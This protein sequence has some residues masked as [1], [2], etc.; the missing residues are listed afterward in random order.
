MKTKQ[1]SR[2]MAVALSILM[3]F[4]LVNW[5]GMLGVYAAEENPSLLAAA[6]KEWRYLSD[7]DWESATHGD[8]YEHKVVQK[9]KSFT[10]GNDN[11]LGKISLQM[12]DGEIR[13][14][15]KGLG[16]I[17]K[18]G[19]VPSIITYNLTGVKASH[20]FSY[21]GIDRSA[22]SGATNPQYG[23]VEKIEV[24]VDDV[25]KFTTTEPVTYHTKAITI[26]FEI[27]E[28]ASKLELKSY[29]GE[30]T[31][32]DEVVFADAR[33]AV[34]RTA[35][36]ITPPAEEEEGWTYLS[37][38]DW[39]EATHGDT[40]K[41]KTVQK[42]KPFSPGNNGR[43]NKIA[44]RMSAGNYKEFE[45]GLGT[46]AGPGN[47]PAV[48]TY[49]LR[50]AEVSEFSTYLGIDR[51]ATYG[52]QSARD[53]KV[54]VVVD[55]QVLYTTARDYPN[56]LDY[57]TDAVKV[58]VNIP[59]TAQKFELK[60]YAGEK[61][62]SDELCF[63]DAKFK[64][65]GT[66]RTPEDEGFGEFEDTSDTSDTWE[67]QPKRMEISNSHPLLMVPLYAHGPKYAKQ[68]RE[69]SFWGDD[70][71]EGKW[72]SIPKELKPYT[73][74]QLHPDDLGYDHIRQRYKDKV[75]AEFYEHHLKLAQEYIDPET[76]EN[77]PI[78]I[79]LT[80][81]TAG[82]L[83]QYTPSYWL[84]TEW[85]DEMYKKYSCLK[86]VFSTE[87]Y[88]IWQGDTVS[89]ATEYLKVSAKNGGYFIWSE[90]NAGRSIE[91][92]M[93]VNDSPELRK[94]LEKYSDYFV[95][96]YKNTPQ[97]SGNDAP[98]V[99]YMKGLWLAGYIDQWGGLMDTWKWYETGK[100]KL[101]AEGNI[102]K[103]QP[104]RQWEIQPEAMLGMESL[105]IYLNG[106][107]VYNYEHPFYTYGVK[108]K[109][110]PLFN[111]VITDF[112][113]Y[114]IEHPAPSKE[115]VL[116]NTKTMLRIN[117]G[118][119][120]NGSFFA[121]LNIE[122]PATSLYTTGRYQAIPAVPNSITRKKLE[123]VLEDTDI[124]ILDQNAMQLR[125]PVS[126][127]AY[128]DEKYE[129]EYTGDIF[130][131]KLDN[132]WFV[133]NYKYNENTNQTAESLIIPNTHTDKAKLW[134]AEVTLE[135][136]T[137]VI[138]EGAE[139]KVSVHLNNYR[140]DKSE[141]WAGAN[142]AAEAIRL[143]KL[144]KQDAVE[145]IHDNYIG[146]TKDTVKR[147]STLV[148]KNLEKAPVIEKVSGLTDRYD[149]PEV[150]YQAD[151]K[152]ATVTVSSNGYVSFEVVVEKE[153]PQP[154][155]E[156]SNEVLLPYVP[157]APIASDTTEIADEE[158]ALSAPQEEMF[159]A[160][161]ANVKESADLELIRK[162]IQ[163]KA[164]A[165][166]LLNK[167]SENALEQ[168]AQE[169]SKQFHD[170]KAQ[171]WYAKELSAMRIL[172]M[173]TGFEDGSFGGERE[174]TGKEYITLLVRAAGL[175]VTPK[176]GQDWFSPYLE[177]AQGAN[178]LKEIDFSLDKK[179]TRQELALLSYR[180]LEEKE[181]NNKETKTMIKDREQ[182]GENYLIA[183]ETLY[184]NNI[185][186]GYQDG[187]FMPTQ[188][189]KRSEVITVLY[190][191]LKR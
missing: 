37:A 136:H 27:P 66:F 10:R 169:V 38:I 166:E 131:Q 160:L 41:N 118:E 39:V 191:L 15:D 168:M 33:I 158:I 188:T 73:V 140:V 16:T 127:K 173:V 55:N 24:V 26:D 129:Q 184:A 87:S 19:E 165:K 14:F 106:G 95:F 110:S 105:M 155:P 186:K 51:S 97:S 157:E 162:F 52:P 75:L 71:L 104:N 171:N 80:V 144:Q 50:G 103:H 190:R 170:E 112:F 134:D 113:K 115:E 174:I 6:Q 133:Y 100:W 148:F 163:Q 182:I 49:D 177:A 92:A 11:I 42:N 86:G 102:G 59:A 94:A 7:M 149:I 122:Y 96:I 31:W 13:E 63:A 47:V 125:T 83:V 67:P 76:G 65:T 17:P 48:I 98:T 138:M 176:G 146:D 28:G 143:P 4:G 61:Q 126:R 130:A 22:T 5:S 99:S 36:Q 89:S 120:G 25:V 9:D 152:T 175:P 135:P 46:V 183:V 114:I 78:P 161:T 121:G 178:W 137:F 187:K 60:A 141:L 44:L 142:N 167:I 72:R 21:V 107:C 124:E 119:R 101:F 53:V 132:R 23:K 58:T 93:G 68:P 69:Y 147:T 57:N 35:N 179:L 8:A 181:W 150:S 56:G 54:E 139:N 109:P 81:Y 145:W 91:K 40:D 123:K 164:D 3:I 88:W 34:E 185:L 111:N 77:A 45:K 84:T 128:F 156:P 159:K 18:T 180:F 108:D 29:A 116:A 20:F 12:Q 151:T 117:Y 1:S 32:A 30:H 62:W 2:V 85:I 64:A 79:M 189:I 74:I 82:N 153:K 70:S 43:S 172:G 154:Q 90:Q